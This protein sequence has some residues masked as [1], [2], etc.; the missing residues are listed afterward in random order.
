[1]KYIKAIK[2]ASLI[3][4]GI[5][6]ILFWF[7]EL[8][9][10]PHL[11]LDAAPSPVNYKEAAVET[12]AVIAAAS[13]FI[14]IALK[15]EKHI[16]YLE[17]LTVICSRCKKVRVQDQWIPIDQWLDGETSVV[18]SHGVCYE[19]LRDLYPEEYQGLVEAGKIVQS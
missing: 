3:G 18:F 9:D 13:V 4:F 11:L 2:F 17:G 5:V 14:L 6:M 12:L 19:C 10:L 15:L 16:K 8:L 1:M 7:N